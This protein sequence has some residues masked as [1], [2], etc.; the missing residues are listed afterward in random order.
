MGNPGEMTTSACTYLLPKWSKW[1]K[2]TSQE[3]DKQ[4]EV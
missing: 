4:Q 3:N 2:N 1:K